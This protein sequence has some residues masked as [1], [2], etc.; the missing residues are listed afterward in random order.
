MNLQKTGVT[1]LWGIAQQ[2]P[3]IEYTFST[4]TRE[5]TPSFAKIE[6]PFIL[7][8][9]LVVGRSK[10]IEPLISESQPEV[11]PLN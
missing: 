2:L 4:T 9:M 7:N 1:N 10:G 5:F 8:K 3:Y 11:L 6:K